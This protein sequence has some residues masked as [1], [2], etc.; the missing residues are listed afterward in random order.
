MMDINLATLLKDVYHWC[1]TYYGEAKDYQKGYA[2]LVSILIIAVISI[3]L[4][5]LHT[6]KFTRYLFALTL[7]LL[8]IIASINGIEID[9]VSICLILFYTIWVVVE[10][11]GRIFLKDVSKEENR[12]A[13]LYLAPVYGIMLFLVVILPAKS[14]PISW[15]GFKNMI[16]LVEEQGIRIA[17]MMEYMFSPNDREFKFTIAGYQEE[18]ENKLGGSISFYDKTS[19]LVS[20]LNKTTQKG[21]LI[22]SVYDVYT[23]SSWIK[24]VDENNKDSNKDNN[25]DKD[26]GI[27]SYY[28]YLELLNGLGREYEKGGD[29]ENLV[30]KKQ[31]QITYEDIRT[32]TLFYP[33]K[34]YQITSRKQSEYLETQ[35]SNL[36]LTKSKGTNYTYDV[37]FYEL[38]L[39]SEKMKEILRKEDSNFVSSDEIINKIA[40]SIFSH[41]KME[42]NKNITALK[43]KLISRRVRIH[44]QYTQIP[45]TIT[46]RT[47]EL[48]YQLT[49]DYKN[50]YDK[51]KAI[52]YFLSNYDYDTNVSRVPE[53][54]DFADYFLFEERRGYC[55]YYATA[56]CILARINNIPT[57]YVEG[58]VVDY[59]EGDGEHSY[60]VKNDNAHAWV[61]A[62]IKGIG[63]IPFEPTSPYYDG[64]Y[65]NWK[66]DKGELAYDLDENELDYNYKV[67]DIF[68]SIDMVN[69]EG[70]PS[71]RVHREDTMLKEVLRV[72]RIIIIVLLLIVSLILILLIYYLILEKRYS[73]KLIHKKD[74]NK[75]RIL[76]QELLMYLKLDG[77]VISTEET[78]LTFSN[79]I[80]D[81]VI[82]NNTTL[83]DLVLIYQKV[84]YGNHI[85]NQDEEVIFLQFL[86][87][88]RMIQRKKIGIFKMFFHRFI[89]LNSK[90]E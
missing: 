51:L 15:N 42:M 11:L 8:L 57:R 45:D 35:L 6:L 47:K 13:T 27:E 67:D 32:K 86:H 4:T 41:K 28:D 60:Y 36:I 76:C 90:Y 26:N 75:L 89:Y 71:T 52:E 23:G 87:E 64:R 10:V 61:E 65:T 22:G 30:A 55:T 40:L 48:A 19:L 14:E 85:L 21:Y 2:Y 56:M 81:R 24:S 29:V 1:M 34:T 7:P 62:Y 5:L 25:K 46:E 54:R 72:V 73:N 43:G 69:K 79:R 68:D 80:G 17:N 84:R 78:F 53:D 63:W 31:Y 16:A 83:N 39:N 9:K 58:F 3:L 82:F 74:Y 66:E 77:Y 20:T 50:D 38:N 18:E 37:V 44:E 88:Y 33:L 12:L 59:I 70:N 49:K